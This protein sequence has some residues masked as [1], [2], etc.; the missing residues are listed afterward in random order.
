MPHRSFDY[1]DA[2]GREEAT[3]LGSI[4]GLSG[5]RDRNGIQEGCL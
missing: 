4:A 5:H 2:P 1:A 3:S